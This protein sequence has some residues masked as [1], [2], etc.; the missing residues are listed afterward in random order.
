MCLDNSKKVGKEVRKH[1]IGYKVY[2]SSH[3]GEDYVR[4]YYQTGVDFKLNN[5]Y[6][7]KKLQRDS[8]YH[9]FTSLSIA[10]EWCRQE[11]GRTDG[12]HVIEYYEPLLEGH[13]SDYNGFKPEM[14]T[15]RAIKILGKYEEGKRYRKGTAPNLKKVKFD[16]YM[17]EGEGV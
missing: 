16:G 5:W 17:D 6:K 12:L 11:L 1:G 15:V 7:A 13:F 9:I 3:F 4:G 14:M 10:L 8:G 2:N